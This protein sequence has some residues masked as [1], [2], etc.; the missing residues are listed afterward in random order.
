MNY[1]LEHGFLQSGVRQD[2]SIAQMRLVVNINALPAN[3]R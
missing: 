2:S 1:I 3:M